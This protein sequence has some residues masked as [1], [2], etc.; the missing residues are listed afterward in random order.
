MR[1][2]LLIQDL[3]YAD[4]MVLVGESMDALEEILR[5]LEGSCSG[6]GLIISCSK[7]GILVIRP[8]NS[9]SGQP[10]SG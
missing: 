9:F 7:T 2:E 4:D 3:E 6:F 10:S 8:S 1:G 5:T